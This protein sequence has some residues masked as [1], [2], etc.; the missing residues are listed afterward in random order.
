MEKLIFAQGN[1][2][3]LNFVDKIFGVSQKAQ[4]MAK[5]EGADKVINATIGSLLGDDGKLIVFDSVVAAMH[6]LAPADF[7]N[8]APINGTPE[9]L[10]VIQ[11]YAF[12]THRPDMFTEAGATPGGAGSIRNAIVNYSNTG[13]KVLTSDWYWAAYKT[14]AEEA[15]RKLDTYQLLDSEGRYNL[16]A[17]EAKVAELISVQQSLLIMINS[18]AHN[19]TGFS[20][21][22]GD[23]QAVIDIANKYATE[24]KKIAIFIDAAYIDFTEDPDEARS[25]LRLFKGISDNVIGLLGYSASKAFTAYGMRCG[26]LICMTNVEEV[27]V[28]F[29]N[30]M[31]FSSR[32]TW[33]NGTRAAQQVLVNLYNDKELKASV[34]SE[35]DA[36]RELLLRRGRAF[37]EAA[38]ECGLEIVP[39]DSGFFASI[40]CSDSDAVGE[41]L[42]KE[43]IFVVPLAKGL[44]VAL[45]SA[46]EAQ[47]RVIAPA[48]KRAMDEFYGK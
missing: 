2:R 45:S 11:K 30:I 33:S 9:F 5:R 47:C 23:W 44:R 21:T 18:P 22:N 46:T 12:G 36:S 32:G 10:D 24:E 19:P 28:E 4:E 38:A 41:L 13:E 15:Y 34:D 43:G 16:A 6:G 20:L 37:E 29:K 17:L 14:L 35:R 3:D 25:F 27:A 39:Y 40:P 48:I 26:A 42:H 1:G 31:A 8:Y 7:A